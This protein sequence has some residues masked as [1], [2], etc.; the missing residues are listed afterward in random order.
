MTEDIL[1]TYLKVLYFIN[2]R[3]KHKFINC[4][5]ATEYQKHRINMDLEILKRNI[6]REAASLALITGTKLP[7]IRTKRTKDSVLPFIQKVNK[8]VGNTNFSP[9]FKH[10]CS[11][12]DHYSLLRYRA[13]RLHSITD[14]K[15][16]KLT[17][18]YSYLLN[19]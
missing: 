19:K 4:L 5:K 7:I 11:Y 16:L 12:T 14:L 10:P 9:D 8:L 3:L 1:K 15:H 18:L 6:E 17:K 13:L 2:N